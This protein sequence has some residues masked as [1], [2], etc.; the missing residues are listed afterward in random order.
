[1]QV[2]DAV[3]KKGA[4]N[5]GQMPEE[6][7]PEVAFVGRSNTGKS[8][9]LNRITG[10]KGLARTS[11]TPG[12]TQE[13]NF[14]DVRV[15]VEGN[16]Q[17]LYCVDLPGFGY[18]KFSKGK[19]EA[20]GRLTVDYIS[21]REELSLVCLLNDS[22]R[23]PERDELALRDMAATYGIPVLV[24]VTKIDRL[25]QKEKNKQLKLIA[26]AYGLEPSD[27]AVTGE[28][29][30]GHKLWDRILPYIEESAL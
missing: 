12:R 27:L 22:K 28:K 30:P 29:T 13:I 16:D 5:L 15:R 19:R 18:G 7:L 20:M 9:L 11:G 1:M 2:L 6:G 24:V 3:F 14:F 21:G 26:A 8:T 25:N 23:K 17:S 10:R 4:H